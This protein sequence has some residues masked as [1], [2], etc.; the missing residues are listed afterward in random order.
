ML[1]LLHLCLE[2]GGSH[3][4]F[5]NRGGIV[6]LYQGGIFG[7]PSQSILSLHEDCLLVLNLDVKRETT[8][9][10]CFGMPTSRLEA[11]R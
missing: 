8:L 10:L 11:D 1:P 5:A 6:D 9:Y 2:F 7:Q 4:P 3:L